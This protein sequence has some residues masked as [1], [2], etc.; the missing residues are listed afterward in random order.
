MHHSAV[1]LVHTSWGSIF[2]RFFLRINKHQGPCLRTLHS[3]LGGWVCASGPKQS[4]KQRGLTKRCLWEEEKRE[5]TITSVWEVWTHQGQQPLGNHSQGKAFLPLGS[6]WRKL[7]A[8]LPSSHSFPSASCH[9]GFPPVGGMLCAAEEAVWF[10]G[11]S[12]IEARIVLLLGREDPTSVSDKH[13]QCP[14]LVVFFPL[15]ELA[16]CSSPGSACCES[17]PLAAF[18]IKFSH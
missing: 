8:S 11:L 14:L 18:I 4:L 9:R 6:S 5:G 17:F 1:L 13:A 10:L 15:S 3:S 12:K 7:Y 16:D 2:K